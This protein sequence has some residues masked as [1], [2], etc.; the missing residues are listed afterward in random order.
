MP[1]EAGERLCAKV[2]SMQLS[3]EVPSS[4]AI[5]SYGENQGFGPRSRARERI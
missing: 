4:M 3:R 5:F 2:M 1:Q